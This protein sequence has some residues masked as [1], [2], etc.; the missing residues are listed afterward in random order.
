MRHGKT[1]FPQ[2]GW[3]APLEMQQWIEQYN[4]AEVEADN[5]PPMS[6]KLANS[7]TYIIASTARR[8]L[9][10]VQALGHTAAISDDVFCEAQLSFALWRFPRLSPFVWAGFFRLLWLFG[11]SRGSDSLQTTRARARI[12]ARQLTALAEHGTV[13]LVG[14]GIMNSLIGKELLASGWSGPSKQ[15]VKYWS[16]NVY[17][18]QT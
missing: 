14:H 10:S 17:R 8:S 11:Y 13:L 5:V 2:S 3:I 16:A 7:A 1:P 6:L 9:S 12:A 15:K 18:F 4:L